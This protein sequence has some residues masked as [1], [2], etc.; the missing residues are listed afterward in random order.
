[1]TFTEMYEVARELYLST[2]RP[3]NPVVRYFGD[4][5]WTI[6][7]EYTLDDGVEVQCELDSLYSFFQEVNYYSNSDGYTLSDEDEKAFLEALQEHAREI[8]TDD[9][10][11]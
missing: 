11:D 7:S 10:T 4:G 2:H 6:R 9:E 1:M 3:I 5:D 8:R